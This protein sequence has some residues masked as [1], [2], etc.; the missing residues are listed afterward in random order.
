MRSNSRGWLLFGGVLFAAS[1]NAGVEIRSATADAQFGLH[2]AS[3]YR[4]VDGRC[5]DC[6]TEKSA[7]WYFQDD[8]I[9]VPVDQAAGYTRGVRTFDDLRQWA[10]KHPESAPP[11]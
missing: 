11:S 5:P 1:A 7:L 10:G 9:A 3:G 4:L 2:A 6:A 8:V